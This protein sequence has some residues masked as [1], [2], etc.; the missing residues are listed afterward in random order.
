MGSRITQYFASIFQAISTF[1]SHL[2]VAALRLSIFVQTYVYVCTHIFLQVS[3]SHIFMAPQILPYILASISNIFILLSLITKHQKICL[4][5]FFSR[6]LRGGGTVQYLSSLKNI[7]FTKTK[8][9]NCC[10]SLSSYNST[11]SLLFTSREKGVLN[12]GIR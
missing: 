6:R 7:H 11:Y 5:F 10:H 1:S 2:A 12:I 3:I 9:E 8:R 4:F